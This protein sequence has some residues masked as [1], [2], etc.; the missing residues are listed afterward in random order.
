MKDL[1]YHESIGV[2]T[3]TAAKMLERAFD[4]EI[5]DPL[6]LK[7]SQFKVILVLG[8]KDGMS[9]KEIANMTFLETPTIVPII[10]K[11]E[12]NGLVQRKT[13]PNDRRNN[14]VFLTNKGRKFL[15]PLIEIILRFRK[16]ITKNI[17][18]K[19]LETTKNVLR[20]ITKQAD[21]RYKKKL[22]AMKN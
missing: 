16:I 22:K 6:G 15:E 5:Q 17:S 9:Q 13:D 14:L 10:D 1:G 7:G 2:I 19:D 11:M 4:L 3:I 12:K 8:V 20:T 21:S 18:T